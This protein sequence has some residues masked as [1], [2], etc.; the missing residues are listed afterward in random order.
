MPENYMVIETEA[1]SQ[2]QFEWPQYCKRTTHTEKVIRIVQVEDGEIDYSML[3]KPIREVPIRWPFPFFTFTHNSYPEPNKEIAFTAHYTTYHGFETSFAWDFGDGN[4]GSGSSVTHSYAHDGEYNVTLTVN[5]KNLITGEERNQTITRPV[6]VHSKHVI[7]PL[8]SNLNA[9]SL[10]TEEDLT[11]VPKNTYQPV[12]I[13]KETSGGIPI[14]QLG[15]HFEEATED[16]DLSSMV[17]DT[18]ITERKS[19]IYMPSWPR[20]IEQYKTLF[21]PSTGAGAVYICSNATSLDD[22]SFENADMVINVGETKDNMTVTTS[23]YNGSKY[24]L[25]YG[26]TGTGGGEAPPN[27]PPVADANGPYTGN[28]GSPITFNGSGSYDENDYIV[29]GLWDLDG[30][31]IYETNATLTSGIVSHTWGDDYSGN[32]SLKVMD[33]FGAIDVDNT[34]VTVLNAAPTVEAGLDQEVLAGDTVYFNGSFTDPGNDTHTIEWEFGDEATA[35]G[36][37]TPTH[38][39][40][41]KGVYN[42]TLTVTD[43]DGGVGTDFVIITVNPIPA[44]VTIKPET[45]NLTSKGEFTA[46]IRLPEPYNITDINISTVVCEGAPAVKGMVADDN[47]YI[48]KFDREDLRK[49]LPTGD[50]VEMTVTGKVFYNGGYADFEGS[51]TIRVIDKGEGK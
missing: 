6:Y 7:S 32:V 50:E 4:Y 13:A 37:L 14:A 51:D 41:D 3:L 23:F 36:I 35:V 45:L 17:A 34:T 24:Y 43:D 1:V 18:N 8:S 20:E 9:T 27:L 22:V 10:L 39:Y 30:D 5:T 21:I 42:V 26:V 16:I 29:S 49:D 12:L 28:E 33:S 44:N 11:Q 15:V 2:I 31:G 47:K 48:A 40:Y 25:V 38:I 46:F 19:L